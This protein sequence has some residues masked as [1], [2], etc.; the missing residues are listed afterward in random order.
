MK[1]NP[2]ITNRTGRVLS[3]FFILITVFLISGCEKT[4]AE[5]YKPV[6]ET[7]HDSIKGLKDYYKD[8]FT[9][10]AAVSP[11]SLTGAQ[12]DLIKSILEV[13]LLKT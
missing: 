1:N 3:Y 13:S 2:C 12:S 10:G 5:I 11:F 9:I 8:Y 6:T 7:N 4:N